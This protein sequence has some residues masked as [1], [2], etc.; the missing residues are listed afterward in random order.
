M[1]AGTEPEKGWSSRRLLRGDP[2]KLPDC[3]RRGQ[4][5]CPP[6]RTPPD[7]GIWQKAEG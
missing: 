2:A 4:P 1:N 5:S 6:R 7:T 3:Q